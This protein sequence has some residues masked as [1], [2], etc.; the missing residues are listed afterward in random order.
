MSEDLHET[1]FYK[2]ELYC[3][4]AEHGQTTDIYRSYEIFKDM[5]KYYSQ[6]CVVTHW[7]Q[8]TMES[9]EFVE[10]TMSVGDAIWQMKEHYI[11]RATFN[12]ID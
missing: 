9:G 5:K 2:G 8:R 3:L 6:Q 10:S 12:T 4:D 1:A 11:E 7:R